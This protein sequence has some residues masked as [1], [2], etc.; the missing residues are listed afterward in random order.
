MIRN[1]IFN[2]LLLLLV[3]HD[4]D[5]KS[6]H[7]EGPDMSDSDLCSCSAGSTPK[8][9]CASVVAAEPH[10]T[11]LLTVGD[12]K[13]KLARKPCFPQLGGEICSIC[14]ECVPSRISY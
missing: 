9:H 3:V 2:L 12:G 5:F 8:D 10:L 13:F 14:D 11:P 1:V 4:Q 7:I 6:L